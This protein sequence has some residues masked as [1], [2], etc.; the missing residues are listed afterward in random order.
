MGNFA[1]LIL[2]A[3][4]DNSAAKL[5][6]SIGDTN[7]L[8]YGT[9]NKPTAAD[10]GALPINEVGGVHNI[11]TYTALSQIGCT[12]ENTILE[13]AAALPGKSKIIYNTITTSE[14]YPATYS[15]VII[16]NFSGYFEAKCSNVVDGSY[17]TGSGDINS[18]R[19]SGWKKKFSDSDV[20]P[21]ANGGTG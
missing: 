10:V 7:Y 5:S 11:K 9:H 13:I 16:E 2:C 19:W 12:I 18:S 17:W 8:I 20:I 6:L 3:N 15:V 14:I 21:V 4:N 1:T